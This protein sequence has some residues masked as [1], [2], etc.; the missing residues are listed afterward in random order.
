[1]KASF[2]FGG[3]ANMFSSLYF[4]AVEPWKSL[5]LVVA[6]WGLTG[7]PQVSGGMFGGFLPIA[8]RLVQPQQIVACIPMILVVQG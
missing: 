1:M 4:K 6:R 8:Q 2:S 5:N 3:N 7:R